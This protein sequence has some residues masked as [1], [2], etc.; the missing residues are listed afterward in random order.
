LPRYQGCPIPDT[1][2]DGINDEEDSCVSVAGLPRFHGCPIPDTDGD[3]INDE[4]DSCVNVAGLP[5]FHG[6][7]DTDGDGIPDPEDKCPNVAGPLKYQGCPVRDSDGDGLNDDEDLCPNQP[8]PVITRGCPVN[9]PPE[10]VAV[11]ITEDFRN[12]LFDFGKS[13]IRPESEP[14]IIKA[15]KT[16]NEEV[17]DAKFYIDGYTDNIGSAVRNKEISKAR[18]LAVVNALV[19]AGVNKSRLT[20]RGFGKDHPKCDNSTESGRQCN[21]RV[22]VV[23]RSK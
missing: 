21:R 2:G 6:C 12:I 18:A 1:D 9:L 13:T 7:P 22:E 15:A 19:K 23:N 11:K 3:G 16:M 10:E 8:G 4:E 5:Q 14:V 17:P 20:A